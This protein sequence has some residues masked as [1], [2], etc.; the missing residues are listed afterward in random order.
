MRTPSTPGNSDNPGNAGNPGNPKLAADIALPSGLT[1]ALHPGQMRRGRGADAIDDVTPAFVL[2]VRSDEDVVR[3][4]DEARRAELAIVPAGG[5]TKLGIGNIAR[6]LDLRVS[7]GGMASII[8]HSPQDMVVTAQAGVS[9]ARLNLALGKHGQRICI[10]QAAD[11]RS[12]IGGIVACNATESFAYGYGTPRDLV[13]GMSVVDG[14]ARLLNPG[15]KVVKN[16]SGYDLV[17]MFTGSY[18]TLGIITSVTLRTHP[19]P[20][21]ERALAID[22]N[23]IV[24]LETLRAALFASHLPLACLDFELARES[25]GWR[26]IVKI[27]GTAGEVDYQHECIEQIAPTRCHVF[28]RAV[29]VRVAGRSNVVLRVSSKPSAVVATARAIADTIGDA[30]EMPALAGRLGDGIMRVR[31]Q[32]ED[33][34]RALNFVRRMSEAAKQAEASVVIERAPSEIKRIIDVW[35]ERPAGF[36]LMRR[37]KDAFDPQGIL[38]PG[39]FVGAL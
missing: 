13:L 11:D 6:A 9:L 37:L 2:T 18:G 22:C 12:T 24:E 25:G 29:P 10:D 33:P 14:K 8:E 19:I 20:L 15:G 3:V 21:A 17:R 28:E 34:R 27:E 23:D 32:E 38:S 31:I 16:V 1:A 36:A 7:L 26:A 5:A 35:G 30:T 39:R 4:V